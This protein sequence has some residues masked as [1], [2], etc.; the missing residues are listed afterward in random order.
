[1]SEY[2][3]RYSDI[4]IRRI[5]WVVKNPLCKKI[6]IYTESNYVIQSNSWVLLLFYIS[7]KKKKKKII[8]LTT[9]IYFMAIMAFI[10]YWKNILYD[11]S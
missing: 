7:G 2:P 6:Y 4:L 3:H 11:Y 10:S 1:M 5:K 8:L 9:F